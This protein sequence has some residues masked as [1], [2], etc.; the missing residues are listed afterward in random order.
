MGVTDALRKHGDR[1]LAERICD[2]VDEECR[3]VADTVTMSPDRRIGAELRA[4]SEN[5]LSQ[6]LADFRRKRSASSTE[7]LRSSDMRKNLT[8][9]GGRRETGTLSWLMYR[10]KRN[11]RARRPEKRPGQDGFA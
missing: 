8:H 2:R 3:G 4:L 9:L 7:R 5:A 11:E 1:E 10:P 6:M